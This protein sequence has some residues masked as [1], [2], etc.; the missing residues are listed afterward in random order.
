MTT[1]KEVE[2]AYGCFLLSSEGLAQKFTAYMNDIKF[3]PGR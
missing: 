2:D 3:W 1:A